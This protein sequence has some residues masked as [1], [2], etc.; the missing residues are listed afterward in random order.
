VCACSTHT[1]TAQEWGGQEAIGQVRRQFYVQHTHA[2]VA[3]PHRGGAHMQGLTGAAAQA[4]AEAHGSSGAQGTGGAMEDADG[5]E[6]GLHS[7]PEALPGGLLGGLARSARGKP[8][9][10]YFLVEMTVCMAYIQY[11]YRF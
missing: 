6:G 3:H 7:G 10:P 2:L 4:H 1:H 9:P 8:K 5:E 11:S